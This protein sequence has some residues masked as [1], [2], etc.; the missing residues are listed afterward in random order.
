MGVNETEMP[1]V[2]VDSV[3]AD[4]PAEKGGLLKGDI[5]TEFNDVEIKTPF[6]LL[7]QI[8]R[9]NC[10][11]LINIKIYRNSGFMDFELQLEECPPELR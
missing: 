11:E 10:G 8:I 3:I 2:L 6:D 1:G 9:Q 5:I 7:T 4:S